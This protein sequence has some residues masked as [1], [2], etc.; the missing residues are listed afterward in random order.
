MGLS[1]RDA[2]AVQNQKGHTGMA[3]G[4]FFFPHEA[5]TQ[6]NYLL[7]LELWVSGKV[8][9]TSFKSHISSLKFPLVLD[10]VQGRGGSFLP[11]PLPTLSCPGL[12]PGCGHGAEGLWLGVGVMDR[13]DTILRNREKKPQESFPSFLSRQGG[14]G[15]LLQ[16]GA[17]RTLYGS[18]QT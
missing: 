9:S 1:Q 12:S 3:L 13:Q 4:Y 14:E 10:T 16:E 15:V 8:N 7:D 6:L 2:D 18:V 5:A 17:A 11:N